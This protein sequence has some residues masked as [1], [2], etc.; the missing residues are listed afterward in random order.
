MKSEGLK[1]HWLHYFVDVAKTHNFTRSAE[2]NFTFQ[3]N[4]SYAIRSLE[5]H[6]G[7]QLFYRKDGE[8]VLSKY[9]I[10]FLPYVEKALTSLDSG[11]ETL[12]NM[13][14]PISGNVKIGFSSI[15]G[16]SIIPDMFRYLYSDFEK[17]NLI[18]SIQPV[19]AHISEDMSRVEDLVLSGACDIGLTCVKSRDGLIHTKLWDMEHVILMAKDHPLSSQKMVTLQQLE[20]ERFLLLE[21]D[22][23]A[24]NYYGR[25]F[26]ILGLDQSNISFDASW[27][28]I[29]LQ[30]STGHYL[31]IAPKG[32]YSDY[33]VVAMPLDHPMRMRD[34]YLVYP[35][36]RKMNQTINYTKN[37]IVEYFKRNS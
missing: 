32:R 5:S 33:E 17:E 37:A 29:V 1:I 35:T 26:E 8:V 12:Q 22:K 11:C 36:G 16:R 2:N 14:D 19:M 13:L 24:L 20:N 4:I 30:V 34:M 3:S 21:G 31:T 10:A 28:S 27:S 23:N 15:F 25:M 9:G 18:I 6:L 7:V